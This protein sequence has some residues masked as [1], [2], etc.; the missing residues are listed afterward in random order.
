MRYINLRLTYLL[1]VWEM[2]SNLLKCN[3]LHRWKKWKSDPESTC[4]SRSTPNVNHF[5]R[6]TF[7][8]AYH[9]WST[10]VFAFVSCPAHRQTDR[11]TDRQNEQTITLLRQPWWSNDAIQIVSA[12]YRH[13]LNKKYETSFWVTSFFLFVNSI[14]LPFASPISSTVCGLWESVSRAAV[15]NDSI[16][17]MSEWMERRRLPS[18]ASN[19]RWMWSSMIVLIGI[20]L[21]RMQSTLISLKHTHKQSLSWTRKLDDHKC[22]ILTLLLSSV[23]SIYLK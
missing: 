12:D 22:G 14:C 23:A 16:S 3:I 17:L 21:T 1:T 19:S 10:S 11:H 15:R 2:V 13:H 8:H 4:E 7:A 6:V 9:V 18:N 20:A 5:Q